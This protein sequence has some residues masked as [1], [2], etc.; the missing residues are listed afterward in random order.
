MHK[1]NVIEQPSVISREKEFPVIESY[2]ILM[3]KETQNK[4][5]CMTNENNSSKNFSIFI[6][7]DKTN[8]SKIE[9]KQVQD[10]KERVNKILNE[11]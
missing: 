11:F 2:C 7:K 8:E 4:S 10:L 1:K 3:E 5:N 9:A 6:D